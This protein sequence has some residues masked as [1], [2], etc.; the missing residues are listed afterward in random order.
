MRL[1][2]MLLKPNRNML[3][4]IYESE[5]EVEIF[6]CPDCGSQVTIEMSTCPNCGVGLLFE[7][8]ARNKLLG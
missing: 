6:E 8:V 7:E 4:K 3:K 5:D 2:T 1:M